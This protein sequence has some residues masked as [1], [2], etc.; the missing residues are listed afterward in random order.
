M[1]IL[2]PVEQ[3][4]LLN[5]NKICFVVHLVGSCRS[6]Y[7]VESGQDMVMSPNKISCSAHLIVSCR[8]KHVESEQNV[9]SVSLSC[10]N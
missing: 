2:V 9:F 6:Q 7:G 4:V 5:P 10:K 3:G 8:T 1:S